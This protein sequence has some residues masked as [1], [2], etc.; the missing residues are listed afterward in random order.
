MCHEEN[1]KTLDYFLVNKKSEPW[2]DSEPSAI[3]PENF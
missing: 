1:N 2:D 3:V